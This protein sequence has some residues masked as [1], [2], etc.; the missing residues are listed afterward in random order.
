MRDRVLI[1]LSIV[2]LILAAGLFFAAYE[3]ASPC[4]QHSFDGDGFTVCP[5]RAGDDIKLVWADEQGAALR[6]FERLAASGAVDATRVRF[7]MNAGM[8][9]VAGAPI[10]LFV[11]N[12]Q[13]EHPLNRQAGSGN[14]YMQPNG[15]FF[16]DAEGRGRILPTV[17]F[18]AA[19]PSS[20]WATQSG[21][22]LVASGTINAAFSHDGPS[23]NI[24][25]GVGIC[26]GGT[27][28]V[29]SDAAVSFGKFARFFRDAL[30]CND[31]LYL[32]GAVSSL[33]VPITGRRDDAY[34]L[35]PIVVVSERAGGG[36]LR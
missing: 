35:G 27:L 14:F 8:F 22:M 15:V 3:A 10:G 26:G 19:M 13:K 31:A 18:A 17:D 29:I 23:R 11:A 16:V 28:F 4:A 2:V 21:P 6:S 12:G 32:D 33:W 36:A 9:D 7:A 30:G 5:Y 20:L 24:R 25:N 1:T 34:A